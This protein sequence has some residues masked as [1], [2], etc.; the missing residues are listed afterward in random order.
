[1]LTLDDLGNRL[2]PDVV[3]NDGFGASGGGVSAVFDRPDFQDRVKSMVGKHRGTPD[4]SL[5][6][7]VDGAVILYYSFVPTR[8]GYHLVG[9]TSEA[10]PEFAGIV[11][12]AAQ[13][14]DRRLGKLGERLYD[15]R[16]RG[17]IDVTQGN[18]TYGPFTN[19][20]G[21]T[22]TVQGYNAGPGYDLASGLGT[23]DGARLVRA[24]AEE[25]EEERD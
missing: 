5:S 6:A 11:A 7:A 2:A 17:I 16:S 4:V 23:I 13:L 12:M 8:V 1:M 10:T 9:G 21:I 24:L 14:A 25:E 3:W 18:N 20:D 19:S 15:L 22:Y